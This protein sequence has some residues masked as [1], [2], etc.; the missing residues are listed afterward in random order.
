MLIAAGVSL[1]KPGLAKAETP[2]FQ[3]V[4]PWDD[5][6]PGPTDLSRL[7][8]RRAGAKGPV[9][10]RGERL[11]LFGVNLAF[12]AALPAHSQ[13]AIVARRLRKLGVNAVRLM[14]IDTQPAPNGL[15]QSDLSTLDPDMLDRL[16]LFVARLAEA[17]ISI[18]LPLQTYRVF[19]GVPNAAGMPPGHKGADMFDRRS[20]A[21]QKTYATELLAHTNA[22]T[23]RA[24]KDDPAL[25]LVEISNEDGLNF[26][27][28]E[29]LLDKLPE[30]LADEFQDRWNAWLR[31][32]YPD[33]GA[34][35]AAWAEGT[36]PAGR[37]LLRNGDFGNGSADWQLLQG[38]GAKGKFEVPRAGPGGEPAAELTVSGKGQQPWDLALQ[39]PVALEAGKTY[40][41]TFQ[42][43]NK[44][45][46]DTTPSQ[47]VQQLAV[48]Q[49]VP[50][51]RV[52]CMN[53][54]VQLTQNWRRYTDTFTATESNP[55]AI[56]VFSN[57]GA[58]LGP[59]AIADV[60]LRTAG[61][62]GLAEG[63]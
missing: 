62:S 41:V 29:G 13:A 9:T 25:V 50:P 16:D 10:V 40:Q 43:R 34:L 49:A 28:G 63:H 31:A 47:R 53:G 11:R 51:Y 1:A 52:Y 42:A 8:P 5:T 32:K 15:L 30:A 56:L 61:F 57:L 37:E 48:Q 24:L 19:P 35:A 22:S 18:D 7:S 44:A 54:W 39:T 45:P 12:G 6:R 4:V 46:G 60:S 36:G 3:A 38:D 14:Q 33:T 59:L 2:L 55:Q 20:I 27:W 26:F 17:G 58:Q 23:G 21:L